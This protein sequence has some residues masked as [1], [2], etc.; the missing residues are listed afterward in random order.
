MTRQEEMFS[1]FNFSSAYIHKIDSI[2][3]N[4]SKFM[5]LEMTKL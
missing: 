4:M 3:K 2:T 5:F 1:G